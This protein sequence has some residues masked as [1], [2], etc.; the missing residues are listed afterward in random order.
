MEEIPP[1]PPPPHTPA[2]QPVVPV[3]EN[4]NEPGYWN[5]TR[6]G[7]AVLLIVILWAGTQSDGRIPPGVRQKEARVMAVAIRDS[8]EQFLADY[9]RLPVPEKAGNREEDTDSD[10]S[11]IEGLATILIGT[12]SDTTP[13]QNLQGV[14]YLEGIKPAKL[15]EKAGMPHAW[16]N[17]LIIDDKGINWYSIVDSWGNIFR[18]RLDTDGGGFV[19]NPDLNGVADGLTKV[20]Q[21]VIVW[22][23]G[24]DGKEETWTDN[25][26][27]WD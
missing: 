19:E 25:P 10:T 20:K 13:R 14:D 16:S 26:K 27:S 23:P 9:G 24:E 22:S 4:D 18:V 6:I 3:V 1:A 15:S 7:F 12:E 8:V 21:R 5:W 11:S 2:F 17:G